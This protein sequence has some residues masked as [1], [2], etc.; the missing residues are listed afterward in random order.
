MWSDKF[1]DGYVSFEPADGREDRWIKSM[2]DRGLELDV[3]SVDT[4][5][6]NNHASFLMS[7]A[8]VVSPPPPPPT[9]TTPRPPPPTTRLP[10]ALPCKTVIV[11][12]LWKR[13]DHYWSL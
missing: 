4:Y 1:F 7:E 11:I 12:V 13:Y 10:P 2:D 8:E 5:S 9:T 6:D 3:G